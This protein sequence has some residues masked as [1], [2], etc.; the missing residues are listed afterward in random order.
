MAGVID[1][2][3]RKQLLHFRS[4]LGRKP[5][6]GKGTLGY[7]PPQEL[8][9][10]TRAMVVTRG[11]WTYE[12]PVTLQRCAWRALV[13]ALL[14]NPAIQP[15]GMLSSYRSWALQAELYER[16]QRGRPVPRGGRSWHNVGVA[17]DLYPRRPGFQYVQADRDALYEAGWVPLGAADPPHWTYRHRP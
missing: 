4:I 9:L 3:D 17:F 2:R 16:Y 11:P 1:P 7:H 6:T 8:D 12:I 13:E 5:C 14:E 10:V 15:W